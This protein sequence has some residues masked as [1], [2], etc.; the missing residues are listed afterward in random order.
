MKVSG[1][2]TT[3]AAMLAVIAAIACGA[4][5]TS[6][7]ESPTD[8]TENARPSVV[9]IIAGSGSGTG[10]IVREDGL[11]V[12]NKHVVDGRRRV[13][14]IL[15]T[16]EEYR[17]EVI[18]RNSVLDLAYVGID[19]DKTFAPL[20][21]GDS[22]SARTGEAVIA[23]GYPLGEELGLEPTVSLGI[24]SAK[25]GRLPANGRIVES[26]QQRRPSAGCQ[27]QRHRSDYLPS[28]KYRDRAAGHRHRL[29]HPY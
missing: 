26:G 19:S 1:I 29:R 8:V 22:D 21:L 14:V 23:I 3:L 4:S 2:L 6:A 20:A 10:F 13:T 27:R 18:K 16:G 9:H 11:V 5:A 28:G 17:G 24:I 25:R 7:P 15:A 12:T